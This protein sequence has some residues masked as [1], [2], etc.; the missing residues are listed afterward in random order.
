MYHD[1]AFPDW[2]IGTKS[3][4]LRVKLLSTLSCGSLISAAS[5][6]GAVHGGCWR[7]ADD[8]ILRMDGDRDDKA[9]G[10]RGR[11][12]AERKLLEFRVQVLAMRMRSGIVQ[13]NQGQKKKYDNQS[14][15]SNQIDKN[16]QLGLFSLG[17]F[18]LNCSDSQSQAKTTEWAVTGTFTL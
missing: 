2:S 13:L 10:N 14:S 3:S 4:F 6:L 17:W 1:T 5:G 12:E 11:S 16:Q 8:D 18:V 7:A 15:K 9:E